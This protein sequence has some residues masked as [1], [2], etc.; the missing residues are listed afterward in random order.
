M[1]GHKS[2]NKLKETKIILSIF[3]NHSETENI[4]EKKRWKIHKYVKIKQY[5]LNNQGAREEIKPYLE[6]NENR[7]IKSLN[8]WH[9]AKLTL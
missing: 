1:L 7:N 3:S 5:T 6:T 9:V 8:L 4:K 2:L